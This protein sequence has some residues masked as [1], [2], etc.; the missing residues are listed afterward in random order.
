T[1]SGI[2]WQLLASNTF[3]QS[4]FSHMRVHPTNPNTL[5]A[6]TTLGTA[7]RG[8]ELPPNIPPTGIFNSSDGGVTWTL[9]LKGQATGLDVDPTNFNN[10]YGALGLF[11]GAAA[12]GVYRSTDGGTTW[13]LITGPWGNNKVGR[14]EVAVAPSA[15]ATLYVSIQDTTTFSSSGVCRTD[16]A[17]D[18]TP[19]W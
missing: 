16:T 8:V 18:P 5:V 7:G 4:S 10:Q 1:N 2:S 3:A 17:W 12:N 11:V 15:P 6:T 19:T 14:I 13:S 9:R